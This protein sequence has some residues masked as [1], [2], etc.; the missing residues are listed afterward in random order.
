VISQAI[1]RPLHRARVNG[2]HDMG[3]MHGFGPVVRERDEPVF[4]GEWERRTFAILLAMMGRRA[5]N[6]DE[7]R[8]TIEQMPPLQ[9]LGASYYERWLH[10]CESLLIE[11]GVVE[12][13][14]IDVVMAALRAGAS[15]PTAPACTPDHPAPEMGR[16]AN[17]AAPSM[18][19]GGDARSL[20]HD[21]SFRPR[22]KAGDRVIARNLNP[23]GHTR[24]PRYVRGHHGVVHRD[25]GVFVF[26]DTHAH[27][28]GAK[29][30]HCYCVQFTAGELWGGDQPAGDRVYVDLWEDY[31]DI[32]PEA[33]ATDVK[34]RTNGSR[35]AMTTSAMNARAA[36]PARK[37][38]AKKGRSRK[39]PDSATSDQGIRQQ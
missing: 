6:V 14:E 17:S 12:R 4:H 20:R 16:D 2:I 22:F 23:E 1:V 31:L 5:F 18:N 24:I 9:Y 30:Q 13:V 15:P 32:Y 7:F 3:G 35:K 39:T 27:G 25:W 36:K 19:P 34:P 10:A 21:Q 26:P 11:K 28:L 33:A 37:R 29:P 38:P 8:R